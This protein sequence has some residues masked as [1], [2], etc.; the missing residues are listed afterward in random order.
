M[1]AKGEQKEKENEGNKRVTMRL[2][3]VERDLREPPTC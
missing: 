1:E 2:V 3:V